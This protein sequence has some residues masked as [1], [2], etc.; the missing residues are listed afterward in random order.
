MHELEWSAS[1]IRNRLAAL[2][3]MLKLAQ[4]KGYIPAR[5]IAVRR[6][7]VT[8][9]SRPDPY[10]PQ[11][12]AALLGAAREFADPRYAC[13]ILLG[14]D[15][16]LRRTEIV[17]FRSDDYHAAS[18]TITVPVRDEDDRPKSGKARSIPI[19]DELVKAIEACGAKPGERVVGKDVWN[20]GDQLPVWL[21]DVWVAAGVT[22]GV[23]L[24]RLRHYWAS[25]LANDG[26][27]TPWELMEWGGWASLDMVRRYYHAPL[28]VNRGPVKAL[29]RAR[30]VPDKSPTKPATMPKAKQKKKA[31]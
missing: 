1:T 20:T 10:T 7:R 2:S 24:H 18:K 13:A 5:H 14:C 17:R 19:T 22:G 27:A 8:L 28:R 23:R 3:G 11:E 6:P 12:V 9:A 30:S 31:L 21:E 15:A 4:R 16:G 29:E 26:K 25:T